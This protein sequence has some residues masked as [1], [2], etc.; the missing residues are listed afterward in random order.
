MK[1]IQTDTLILGAGW[2]GLAAADILCRQGRKTVLLEK[3]PCAGGLARTVDFKGF[4][5]D[6]GGHRLYFKEKENIDYLNRIVGR[7]N[8]VSLRRNSRIFFDAKF[9]DYPASISSICRIDKRHVISILLDLFRRRNGK[10]GGNF[11][12]W[13]KANYGECLYRIY[14]KD[15]TEKVWGLKCSDLSSDWADKRIGNNNLF[16]LLR[17]IFI[18]GYKVKDTAPTFVYPKNGMGGLIDSLEKKIGNCQIY[19]NA[20]LEK[21]SSKDGRLDSASF[22][23]RGEAFELSFKDVVSTI[24]IKELAEVVPGMN[25]EIKD[26]VRNQIKYRSL[27][28][29]GLVI[30]QKGLTA[31]H[32]CYFPSKDIPFSRI[33]EPKFWLKGM[34]PDDKTLICMEIFC[35]YADDLWNMN[36]ADMAERVSEGL[37][38]TGL[39]KDKG[40][41]A[42][43]CIQKVRYAYP[44]H[45]CGFEKPLAK[46]KD[47]FL[48]FKNLKLLGRSGTHSYFD[49]EE[50]L[51]NTRAVLKKEVS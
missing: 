49:M 11:E 29:V 51:I 7:E 24:P 30:R 15:Y 25:P 40:A 38:R 4:K 28:L 5:F 18:T 41:I 26:I 22:I 19:R 33:H 50:C 23:F 2:S 1:K 36:D 32:W 20:G 17:S 35:D 47:F 9:I 6:L 42:D 46:V 21:L 14:F 45:F 12:E 8:L 31:W 3:E 43:A 37:L 34:A 10:A 27:V 48:G 44:L 39:L 16:A 13:V